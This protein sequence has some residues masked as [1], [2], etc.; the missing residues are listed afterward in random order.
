V[1][2]KDCF[3][4]FLTT[5]NQ[6][7]LVIPATATHPELSNF[8]VTSCQDLSSGWKTTQRGGGCHTTNYFCPQCMVNRST[9]S[10]CKLGADR[11]N[12]CVECG[13]DSCCCHAVCD[14]SML[15]ATKRS[16]KDY[17]DKTFD[18]DCKVLQQIRKKSKLSYD[19]GT[20]NSTQFMCHID[21]EPDSRKEWSDFKAL[22]VD[23]IK[24]RLKDNQQKQQLRTILKEV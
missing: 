1:T 3:E 2:Y 21:F 5:F 18:K 20:T 22:I 4:D 6:P 11:C 16:I 13:I 23:E 8:E 19:E 17:I 12:M 14:P 9:M 24:L 10:L 15:E 7:Q